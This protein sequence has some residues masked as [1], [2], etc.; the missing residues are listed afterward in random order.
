MGVKL[1]GWCKDG[2]KFIWTLTHAKIIPCVIYNPVNVK[3]RRID[4]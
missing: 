1:Q 3:L 2:T 4:V